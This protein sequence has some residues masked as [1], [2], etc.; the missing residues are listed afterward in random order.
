MKY[1]KSLPQLSVRLTIFPK[2]VRELRLFGS[3]YGLERM[4]YSLSGPNS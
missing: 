4:P 3:Y 1:V 2:D